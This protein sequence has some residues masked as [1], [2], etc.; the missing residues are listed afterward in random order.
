MSEWI[1][2]AEKLSLI[3]SDKAHDIRRDVPADKIFDA[4]MAALISVSSEGP[5]IPIDIPGGVANLP[6]E[7]L[8]AAISEINEMHS[9]KIREEMSK[10]GIVAVED[11]ASLY[12]VNFIRE[13]ESHIV[14]KSAGFVFSVSKE[15]ALKVV[16]LGRM[17]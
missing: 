14:L 9:S 6:V 17:P 10:L 1:A 2:L 13:D 7:G 4:A 15:T 3:I 8:A 16:S 11:D 5:T 12:S